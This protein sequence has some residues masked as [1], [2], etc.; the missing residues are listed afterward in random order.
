MGRSRG[1]FVLIVLGVLLALIGIGVGASSHSSTYTPI[2]KGTIVHYL[3]AD[4]TGYLQLD[5][6]PKLYI[7]HEGEFS[8]SIHGTDTFKD[9][10]SIS[11]VADTSD[12]TNIDKTSTIGT[13][14]VG[15]A[16]N[17]V[18]IV[19]YSDNG[20]PQNTYTTN[21][22]NTNGSSRNNWGTGGI[23]IV[24]G[25]LM[26]GGSFFLP[27]KKPQQGFGITPGIPAMGQ[28]MVNPYNMPNMPYQQSYQG[29]PPYQGQQPGQQLPSSPYQ[30]PA[31]PYPGTPANPY[32]QQPP[33]QYPP[34]QG[35]GGQPVNPYGQPQ[36]SP[37]PQYPTYEPTQRAN[38]YE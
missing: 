13:H 38:P 18:Q 7:V 30:Q 31:A 21:A 26:V 35:Q 23:L 22:Y 2:S 3:S 27:R 36:Q 20:Q 6:S 33:T 12:T 29:V 19:F 37:Y 11:L 1:F 32:G 24:L 15:A 25:L 28:P 9:G 16:A 10:D 4:G 34:Y 17:V 14:L 8:P 5:G